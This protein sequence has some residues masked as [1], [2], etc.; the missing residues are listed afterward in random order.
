MNYGNRNASSPYTTKDLGRGYAGAVAVSVSIALFSRTIFAGQLKK[1]K[2]SK[3]IIANAFLNYFAGAAAGASNLVLMRQ[4]ELKDGIVVQNKEGDKDY[5]KSKKAGK[6]AIMETALSRVVLP[7]PVLF[8]PALTNF[9]LEK[10]RLW[11]RNHLAG[12]FLELSLC[13]CSLTFALP[14]SIALFE[15]R[16]SLSRDDIDEEFKYIIDHS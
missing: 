13:C 6:K 12:K 15:Q 8:F 4:K 7:L 14:M 9:M 16:A 2:G 3:L 10:L 1:L 5:G 11:P